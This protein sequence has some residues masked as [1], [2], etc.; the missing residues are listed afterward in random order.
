MAFMIKYLQRLKA[1]KGFTIVELIVVIAIIA[2]MM[3]IVFA[4]ITSKDARVSEANSAARDFYTTLQS[5]MTK[6]SLYEGPLSPEYQA[7]P[8]LGEMRYYEKM[9]GNYPFRKGSTALEMPTT[10]SLYVLFET[11]NNEINRVT[12]YAIESSDA[13]YAD[14]VGLYQLVNADSSH[15]NTVFGRLLRDEMAK[16]MNYRDGYYYAKVTYKSILTGTI[17]SRMEA[18]TVKVEY[19]GYGRDQLES[20]AANFSSFKNDQMYFGDNYVLVNGNV[21]GVCAP[22]NTTTGTVMGT[23][24]TTL[25]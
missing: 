14:G 16:R 11:K 5:I 19:T 13:G 10:T 2:V 21:F 20:G 8:N 9:G 23:A 7:D 15:Q 22:Y 1:R 17:P 4:S 24:G 25:S 18:E 6:F 3:G 12:T